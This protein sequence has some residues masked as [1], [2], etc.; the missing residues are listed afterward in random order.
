[1]VRKEIYRP[2]DRQTDE[3]TD[4][5][6]EPSAI[7]ALD[8]FLDVGIYLLL[9]VR[10]MRHMINLCRSIVLSVELVLN[11]RNFGIMHIMVVV[12]A[13]TF[14]SAIWQSLYPGKQEITYLDIMICSG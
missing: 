8:H 14:F 9:T 4:R 5:Q 2:R 12:F 13:V 11:V 6:T 3:Q 1:M 10:D 7:P